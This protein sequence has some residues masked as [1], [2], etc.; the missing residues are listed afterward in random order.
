MYKVSPFTSAGGWRLEAR[1]LLVAGIYISCNTKNFKVCK[2]DMSIHNK[3]S[4]MDKP[5][6]SSLEPRTKINTMILHGIMVFI[7]FNCSGT[8]EVAD[9]EQMQPHSAVDTTVVYDTVDVQP[10]RMPLVERREIN[11]ERMMDTLSMREKVGQLFMIRV[12]A[13]FENNRSWGFERLARRVDEGKVGG[14]MVS[15]GDSYEAARNIQ[16]MQ[17]IAPA[18]LLVAADFEWGLPMRLSGGTRFPENMAIG[19]TRN[20]DYAYQ[21]GE[22]TAEEAKAMGVHMNFAPV[23]D[24]NNNPDNPII[25]IRSYGGQ[26]ELVSRFGS[27]YIEGLQ[28][29][30]VAATVKHFPGHGDTD[31]DSHLQL[32]SLPFDRKRLNN[33]ELV[34]FEAA[35]KA[36]AKAL[37]VAHI[38]MTAFSDIKRPATLSPFMVDSLL[39]DSLGYNGVVV[40]DA[41]TMGGSKDG[42]WPGEAAVK[43]LKA[44][45]DIILLPA[46][47]E[48]AYRSVLRAIEDGRLSEQ[49]INES[50]RR[51]LNLKKFTEAG[52]NQPDFEQM[53]EHIE[54]PVHRIRAGNMFEEALTLV[55]DED[56][57]LPIDPA[58]TDSILTVI[59]TDDMNYGY[60]GGTMTSQL[61]HYFDYNKVVRIGPH[62]SQEIM[63]RALRSSQW[64]DKVVVG[65][66]V[67]FGSYKG[68]LD[69]PG[70]LSDFMED[71]LDVNKP[72]ATVGFGTP[73]LLRSFPAASTYLTTYSASH[74]AQRAAVKGVVGNQ[75]IAGK[76]PIKLPSG[77]DFGHGMKRK[78]ITTNWDK[79]AAPASFKAVE[80][81]VQTAITDSVA[82]GMAVYAARDG[83]VFMNEGFGHY[84]YDQD[85]PEVTSETIF[86]LASLTKVVATTPVAMKQ[87]EQ[88]LLY[89]DKPV[90]DYIPDF[91]GGKKEAVTIR[92]LLSHTGGIKPYMRFWKNADNPEQVPEMI[93][94][95]KL[96]Y[97]PGEEYHY[98]DPG[99]ILLQQI[100]EMLGGASLDD[101]AA[102]YFY[103]PLGM[104]NTMFNPDSSLLSRIAPTEYDSAWRNRLVRG[105][106]HDENAAFLGG[107]AG[108]AGLFSTTGD[109]GRYAQM[110][111]SNGYF[112]GRKYF[113]VG[114]IN[115]FTTPQHIDPK[116]TR[117][118]GWDTPSGQN[119]LYG[120]M[121]S[122]E[123]FGHT[124]FTGTSMLIDPETRTIIILLTN[125]VYPTRKNNK[126]RQFRPKFHDAVMKALNELKGEK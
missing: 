34:P 76:L 80:K 66:F 33:M 58:R 92:Q 104:D 113:E 22:A 64:V 49:M 84:T 79:V 42:Y 71:L 10:T 30:G 85:S 54:D 86:D 101:L 68:R 94:N 83:K 36:D 2:I 105:E 99:Y 6:A 63:D 27:R 112:N 13:S 109:L 55:K 75:K 40:T 59:V 91:T 21:Q 95:M 19:A 11:V 103:R 118:L 45:V 115:E 70:D 38:A 82:P 65:V 81:L 3:K 116:S 90:F 8:S 117:A 41:L 51:V 26:P 29:K 124:G 48:L 77:Y 108:H 32:P 52:K 121:T 61:R 67:R 15:N 89:L 16:R 107:V 87:Y 44:G 35:I 125:R 93:K 28:S 122:D 46:D 12:S 123:A 18:P 47:F 60:P 4:G 1:G 98:S 110:L 43:A 37:M 114:T 50:V 57:V 102:R 72:V 7:L 5:R 56:S 14:L 73:Y 120:S 100:I 53:E 17:A 9:Q 88:D 24:V 97:E 31:V 62:T 39:R 25:N 126:I 119:S 78:P 111:L 74:D 69:L 106:V 96:A 20:P 23:M